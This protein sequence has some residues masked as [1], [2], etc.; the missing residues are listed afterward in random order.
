MFEFVP[1]TI[2]AIRIIGD[3]QYD[4]FVK[5]VYVTPYLES[6]KSNKIAKGPDGCDGYVALKDEK[7]AGLFEFYF[8]NGIME[9]GVALSPNLVGKGL[10]KEFLQNGINFGIKNYEYNKEYIRL[11]VNE[12]NQPAIRVYEKV[13]FKTFKKNGESVEM[14]KKLIK[15]G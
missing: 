13:G 2:D 14:R 10:G 1:A 7:V 4:G 3:W 15:K 6:I 5:S 11:T 9:I 12:N 8:E